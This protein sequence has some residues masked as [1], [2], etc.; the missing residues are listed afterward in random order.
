MDIL[1]K[2]IKFLLFERKKVKREKRV[3]NC[4]SVD[5]IEGNNILPSEQSISYISAIPL[6]GYRVRIGI[7]GRRHLKD[8]ID[9]SFGI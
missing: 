7:L 3:R 1:N 4:K 9:G 5:A 2:N 8:W 6:K